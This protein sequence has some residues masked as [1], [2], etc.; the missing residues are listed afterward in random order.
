MY[1]FIMFFFSFFFF[2]EVTAE[3]FSVSILDYSAD[4]LY[5]VKFF[6]LHRSCVSLTYL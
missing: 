5:V 6:V 2:C 1:T 4:Y 3:T